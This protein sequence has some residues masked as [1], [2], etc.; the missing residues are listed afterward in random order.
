V[1]PAVHVFG[2]RHHGP[3]SARSLAHALE[4]FV[5]DAVLVEGPPDADGLIPLLAHEDTSPPVALLVH[6][7]EDPARASFYPFASFS[8]EYVALRYAL[9]QGIPARFMDLPVSLMLADENRDAE[10]SALQDPLGMLAAAAGMTDGERWWSHL[11]EERGGHDADVFDAILEAM[12]A[13]REDAGE[14]SEFEARREAHMRQTIRAA[15]KEGFQRVAVVCGAWHAP[16]LT[17]L[18]PA[19]ADAD[20]L[21]GLAKVKVAA[22]LV[23]WTHGRLA[24]ASGYGAGVT[25]PGW[26]HHLFTAP[27]RVTERWFTRAAH[28]LREEGLDASSAHVIEAVRLAETLAAVRGRPLPGLD[29]VNE[30]ALSIFGWDTNLPLR[31]IEERLVVGETLG[32]VPEGAPTVPLARDVEREQKRLRLKPEATA[33]EVVLDLRTD[34]DLARSH[35][36]HRLA[37]LGVPWGRPA[38]ASGRGTFKE[39]WALRWQ[40]EFSVRLIDASR[41]GQSVREAASARA[42]NDAGTLDDLPALTTLLENVRYADLSDALAAVLARVEERAAHAGDV[43]HILGALPALARL[44][45][46]GDVRR[47]SA[48]SA[49]SVFRALLARACVNLP[50]ACMNLADDAAETLRVHVGEA[51]D[52]VRLVQNDEALAAWRNALRVVAD[53]EAAHA[54]LVG[55]AVR[56]LRDAGL[57]EPDDVARRVGVALAPVNAPGRV[58][59]WLDGFLGRSGA[60]LVHDATL[61]GLLDAWLSQLAAEVFEETLPLLRRVF[62]RFER[63]ERREIGRR[64]RSGRPAGRANATLDEARARLPLAFARKLLGLPAGEVTG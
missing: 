47:S 50:L 6:A 30:T 57:L 39:A 33:R 58:A 13:L 61:L 46:Y 3:G 43:A 31:L 51:D 54:L 8:P 64:V 10:P 52:A 12:R 40:P 25:S 56:R 14:P 59:A 9:R 41:W 35:L 42:R 17:S 22:T 21:K 4:D 60:L 15:L 27:D 19:K 34:T 5:P 37:L 49:A 63:P 45:R 20:L 7:Q 32:S 24:T 53:S 38:H 23:P 62:S 11:V 55:D 26:Y 1:T 36:L 29:E 28:L 44:V 18:G 48:D 16:V 2:I